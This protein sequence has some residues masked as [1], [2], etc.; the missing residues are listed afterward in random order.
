MLDKENLMRIEF[1]KKIAGVY[2]VE[3]LA[4]YN[5]K[6]IAEEEVR[7]VIKTESYNPNVII[8]EKL[9][10]ENVFIA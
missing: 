4:L 9:Q 7:E 3:M 2:S 10:F 6:R 1:Q 8:V 5:L